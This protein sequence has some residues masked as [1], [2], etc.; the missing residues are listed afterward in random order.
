MSVKVREIMGAR[1]VNCLLVDASGDIAHASDLWVS[2]NVQHAISLEEY[3]DYCCRNLGCA[4]L[5]TTDRYIRVRYRPE[6][7]AENLLNTLF[8]WLADND[9][10]TRVWLSEYRDQWRDRIEA[11]PD[12]AIQH[13]ISV[14]QSI[15]SRRMNTYLRQEVS[16]DTVPRESGLLTTLSS[17]RCGVLSAEV[18][19]NCPESLYRGSNRFLVLKQEVD[20]QLYFT[21]HGRGYTVFDTD[22]PGALRGRPFK[23]QRNYSLLNEAARAY[24]QAIE[25]DRPVIEKVDSIAE[26]PNGGQSRLRHWRLVLPMK[27]KFGGPH[28]VTSSYDDT[29]IDLRSATG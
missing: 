20:Q 15:K 28:L 5:Q 9:P 17:W 4:S 6:T 19:S 14:T 7:A 23:V 27:N 16:F 13:I 2:D 12:L 29:S 21:E 25:Q 26:M 18:E 24:M 10:R 1:T 22:C 11:R 8:Y 3:I